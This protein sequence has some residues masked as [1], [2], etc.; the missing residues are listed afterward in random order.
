MNTVRLLR[1]CLRICID[2]QLS[3]GSQTEV[4]QVSAGNKTHL[5]HEIEH[6]EL[7][8]FLKLLRAAF[9]YVIFLCFCDKSTSTIS[10]IHV[11]LTLSFL[12]RCV[13]SISTYCWNT[14]SLFALSFEIRYCAKMFR[15]DT[16]FIVVREYPVKSI[17]LNLIKLHPVISSSSLDPSSNKQ[18]SMLNQTTIPSLSKLLMLFGSGITGF[19]LK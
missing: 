18:M 6:Q 19:L 10:V 1:D 7:I 15:V 14:R 8:R 3:D 17:L 12:M 16:Y 11:T 2:F 5:F 9:W 13:I 4:S